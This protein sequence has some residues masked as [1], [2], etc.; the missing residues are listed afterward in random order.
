[1]ITDTLGVTATAYQTIRIVGS[2]PQFGSFKDNT[3]VLVRAE[4]AG[5]DDAEVARQAELDPKALRS[6]RWDGI[7]RMLQG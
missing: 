6:V 7:V 2:P 5:V 4:V 1:M 3:H